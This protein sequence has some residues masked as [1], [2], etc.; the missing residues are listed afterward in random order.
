MFLPLTAFPV[1]S[2]P[3]VDAAY[4]VL[5]RTIGARAKDFR[6]SIDQP[7]SPTDSFKV[8]AANGIVHVVATSGVALCRGAY[9]YL[10]DKCD[11]F[12][13]WEGSNIHLPARFPDDRRSGYC[14]VPF[15]HYYNICTF[16]YTTAF[17]DWAR[18]RR[19]IDWMALHGINMPLALTGQDKVWQ[20]VFKSYGVPDSSLEAFFSGPAFQPWHWMGNLNG[21]GGPVSQAWLDGQAALQ[22]EILAGERALGMKP[23]VPGFSGFVPTDFAKYVPRARL[24]SPT[25]WC[26]FAPTTFIDIRDPLFVEIGKRFVQAYRKLY[27]SDHLYLCDT[28]NE[29]NP[30]FPESTKLA[31]L[32]NAG[33]SVYEG[34]SEA[35]PKAI[36]VM[37]GWLFY[38]ASGYWKAPEVQALLSK[39]PDGKMIVLD[40]ACEQ[41]EV[42]KAQPLV[43]KKGFVFCTLHNFGQNT[44]LGGDLQG[45][46]DR[47]RAALTTALRDTS[48]PPDTNLL[49][50]GLTPEGIDQNPVMVELMSD[51]MWLHEP[52]RDGF[53]PTIPVDSW[54]QDYA[55]ARFGA[56]LPQTREAWQILSKAVY[57]REMPWYYDQWRGRPGK[58]KKGRPIAQMHAL[59]R[60]IGLL[61]QAA[62]RLKADPCYQRDLV[63][64]C[65]TWLGGIA[66]REAY[67]AMKFHDE[68]PAK[69]ALYKSSFFDTLEDIDRVMATRPE[70]RLTTWIKAAR[71][72]GSTVAEKNLFERDARLQ[73]TAWDG[74]GALTDYANKEWA[75][76]IE[77]FI[78]RRWRL[79]FDALDA[80][81]SEPSGEDYLGL[82]MTWVNSTTTPKES[83]PADAATLVAL[84][85]A[86]YKG[87]TDKLDAAIGDQEPPGNLARQG[88][89]SDD[90]GTEA[91]G[92]PSNAIDGD[93]DTYWA[94]H[95]YPRQW[96]LDL[97]QIH[98]IKTIEVFPYWGDRRSYQY[99]IDAS[100]DGLDWRQVVDMSKNERPS[101]AKGDRFVLD[102]AVSARFLRI[103]MLRNS[104]NVGVHLLEV[105]VYDH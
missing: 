51:S 104:A 80:G 11:S 43:A 60:G 50:F 30:Q 93:L 85:Y 34:L 99:T 68:D 15:R 24:Q 57:S 62:P 69:Y 35:D 81:K 49:G 28:F 102:Q 75:G 53:V 56:D 14:P 6:L 9:E 47:E 78:A 101:T 19:E 91:G 82:E 46:V 38:N 27:G 64:F 42:W 4:G 79:F 87:E 2:N 66:D 94:A 74:R 7:N 16:G 88:V 36:W 48:R 33:R 20:E 52:V 18:W 26:N 12:V 84:V 92:S 21:H 29:Q 31:D 95:P 40:L 54:I 39:V 86:K 17:W 44:G 58:L 76:L 70:H 41:Y 23:V 90:G 71:S 105:R 55:R 32:A 89:A 25:A 97:R 3:Q 37:Q 61:L 63:D 100:S 73:I 59:E 67:G 13:S 77:D 103:E 1:P 72:W 83:P 96:R 45:N 22:K 5:Q 10:K 98:P 8:T 65:K